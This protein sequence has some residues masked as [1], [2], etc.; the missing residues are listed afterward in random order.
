MNPRQAS[1]SRATLIEK[2]LDLL[3]GKMTVLIDVLYTV[4]VNGKEQNAI[5]AFLKEVLSTQS[6][7]ENQTNYI[8]N[9]IFLKIHS[10]T[11]GNEIAFAEQQ[12]QA[13]NE[14]LEKDLQQSATFSA[15]EKSSDFFPKQT[16][17]LSLLHNL[18]S[19]TVNK[20][21][22]RNEATMTAM[23]Q[24]KIL[25]EAKS[26]DL[27]ITIINDRIE[28]MK[29]LLKNDGSNEKLDNLIQLQTEIDSLV[30]Q[31]K[32][33]GSGDINEFKQTLQSKLES[34]NI[35]IYA[36]YYEKNTAEY[37][38]LMKHDIDFNKKIIE[39]Q[40][41][42]VENGK[43]K[44]IELITHQAM[45]LIVKS[46][47]NLESAPQLSKEVIEQLKS[48]IETMLKD[49]TARNID[50]LKERLQTAQPSAASSEPI[51][52]SA[53]AELKPK[54]KNQSTTPRSKR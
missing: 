49:P 19:E 25:L 9:P 18:P 26:L 54:D 50:T 33:A 51:I 44:E 20:F 11:F 29:L 14:K 40:K 2:K 37:L 15:L 4:N 52:K 22:E 16:A 5:A 6:N 39:F 46:N 34:A 28:L 3:K 38:D 24:S 10:E 36:I 12:Y 31:L 47:L 27:S 7:F 21:F 53:E 8:P 1:A 13:C 23:E 45:T 30:L 32:S 35:A 41:N 42:G 17:L 43:I 48:D